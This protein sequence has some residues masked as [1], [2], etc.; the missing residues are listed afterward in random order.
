MLVTHEGACGACSTFQD[1]SV[2]LLL[3]D[4]ADKGIA[5]AFRSL[6]DF[7]DG[8]ECYKEIGFSD[9]CSAIWLYNT[10]MTR[11]AC[12]TP[13]LQHASS[14]LPNNGPAPECELVECIQCDED[15]AGPIFKKFAARTRRA[16]G[17][18]SQIVRPCSAVPEVVH[19]DPCSLS[20][21]TPSASPTSAANAA[22][23]TGTGAVVL[24]GF[25]LSFVS[26][27]W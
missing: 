21:D 10:N 24:L 26:S 3:P 13:C 14:G 20:I 5:C 11:S 7:N 1:L 4:L 2:Y 16:S 18:L 17:L 9:A 22:S 25:L 19:V 12:L 15:S 8:L 23:P 27:Y 6:I